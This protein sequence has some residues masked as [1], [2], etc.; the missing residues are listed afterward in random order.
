MHCTVDD[1]THL[2][3]LWAALP[4]NLWAQAQ[5]CARAGG[6]AYSLY[7]ELVAVACALKKQ[8]D[9]Q[10]QYYVCVQYT[11]GGWQSDADYE[12]R[13]R[14]FQRI[15]QMLFARK[16]NARP[17]WMRK[18]PHMASLLEESL[19]KQAPSHAEYLD[20]LTLKGRLQGLALSMGT[21]TA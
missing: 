15:L 20:E 7:T 16:P 12:D 18:L 4:C 2:Y 19:Y 9:A 17:E 3:N 21:K 10:A 11:P 13:R 1:V 5:C 14:T 8:H 6:C